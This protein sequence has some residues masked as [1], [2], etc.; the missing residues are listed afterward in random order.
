[1][2]VCT[3]YHC[4]NEWN[5]FPSKRSHDLSPLALAGG[6]DVQITGQAVLN[7]SCV[8]SWVRVSVGKTME[9]F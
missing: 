4:L 6:T 9:A 5:A 7:M 2:P 3:V 8:L 1:M